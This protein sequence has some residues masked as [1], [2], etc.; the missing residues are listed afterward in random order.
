MDPSWFE[1]GIASK[2][3]SNMRELRLSKIGDISW[4]SPWLEY[5]FSRLND[6]LAT[7]IPGLQVFEWSN[8]QY[9]DEHHDLHP[10]GS[11]TALAELRELTLDLELMTPKDAGYSAH[12]HIIHI[13][14]SQKY[15]PACLPGGSTHHAGQA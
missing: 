10:F 5:D 15:L 14:R 2:Q 9:K 4:T 11:F 12:D 3:W 8:Q 13:L 1:A 6:A 7:N